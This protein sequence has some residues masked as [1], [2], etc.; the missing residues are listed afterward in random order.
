MLQKNLHRNSIKSYIILSLVFLLAGVFIAIIGHW[1]LSVNRDSL[2]RVYSFRLFSRGNFQVIAANLKSMTSLSNAITNKNTQLLEEG[3]IH[4]ESAYGFLISI[5]SELYLQ[6]TKSTFSEQFNTYEELLAQYTKIM[7]APFTEHSE[8]LSYQLQRQ[9]K[10][11]NQ[12][13]GYAESEFWKQRAEDFENIRLRNKIIEKIYWTL[14]L[15][16]IIGTFI[17]IYFF[18]E[19]VKIEKIIEQ[20]RVEMVANSR[21]AALGNFSAGVAHEINNPLTVILWRAKSL[22]KSLKEVLSLNSKV[23]TDLDSIMVNTSRIEKIIKSIKTLSKN[24]ESDQKE[25]VSIASL[26]DQLND[27]LSPKIATESFDFKFTSNCLEESL[28]VR[29]VQ[30]IQVLINLINNSVEAIKTL[31]EKWVRVSVIKNDNTIEISVTDS[32]KGIPKKIQP[33][34]F[35]L[36]FTTKSQSKENSGIGLPLSHQIIKDHHGSLTYN[37]K[38]ENTQFLISIPIIQEIQEV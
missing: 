24:A 28:Y 16:F 10:A 15:S 7:D 29:E 8:A 25:K 34:L 26:R 6:G 3:Y 20:Q 17:L 31:D 14:V 23:E 1:T 35:S 36:F 13:L 9:V 19:R 38:S 30:I 11:L 22:K 2:Q 21:L 37:A 5:D 12:F 27:I 32:G 4:L 33:H 18:I